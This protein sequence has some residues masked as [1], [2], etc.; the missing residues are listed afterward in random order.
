MLHPD[1]LYVPSASGNLISLAR[2]TAHLYKASIHKLRLTLVCVDDT[3]K[4]GEEVVADIEAE[5]YIFPMKFSFQ[6]EI[7]IDDSDL[8]P[9][10]ANSDFEVAAIANRG[11][12][13]PR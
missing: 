6:D 5:N 12:L 8:L 3:C 13:S 10:S 9:S 1:S 7:G 11:P 2:I 4:E